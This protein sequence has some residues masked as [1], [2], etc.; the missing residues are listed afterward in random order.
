M[1]E[2][3]KQ[4][5]GMIVGLA[6]TLSTNRTKLAEVQY[7][8]DGQVVVVMYRSASNGKLQYHEAVWLDNG[9]AWPKL[10]KIRNDLEQLLPQPKGMAMPWRGQRIWKTASAEQDFSMISRRDSK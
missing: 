10:R 3:A 5:L 2:E 7:L 4:E 8:G 1:I 6:V 9:E